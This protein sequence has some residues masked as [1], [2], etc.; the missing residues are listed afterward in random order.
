M[1][2]AYA[3]QALFERFPD[4]KL[5]AAPTRRPLFTLHG[6]SHMPVALGRRHAP[7]PT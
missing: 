6:Y 7:V 3:L 2:A 5:T 1:E 4:L